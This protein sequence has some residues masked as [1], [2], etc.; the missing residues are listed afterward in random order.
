MTCTGSHFSFWKL[1]LSFLNGANIS[2]FPDIKMRIST[3]FHCHSIKFIFLHLKQYLHEIQYGMC[4]CCIFLI[5]FSWPYN[6]GLLILSQKLLLALGRFF[7]EL[8]LPENHEVLIIVL[9]ILG[10]NMKLHQHHIYFFKAK[11]SKAIL[12]NQFKTMTKTVH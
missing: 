12:Y 9:A 6:Y 10:L 3:S 7:Q 5:L 2:K 1:R 4:R 11:I 8:Q